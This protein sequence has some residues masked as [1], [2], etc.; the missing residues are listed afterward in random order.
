VFFGDFVFRVFEDVYEPAEDSF[1]F[2]EN[3]AVESGDVVLDMGCGCGILGIVAAVKALRV[4]CV[5]VNP[6]AVRGA[7]EN[8]R[9][10]GVGDRM[11]FV[12]GDLFAPLRVGCVF[13]LVLFNAP[14]L[15]QAE[16]DGD[17]G[18]WVERAWCGGASGRV[19]IDR[20]IADVEKYVKLGGQVLLM[21]SSLCGVEETLRIFEENGFKASVVAECDLP[22][23]EKL[24]LVGAERC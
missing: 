19:V 16:V 23:F 7:W 15:P 20:F 1:L 17:G 14:F 3:L 6:Y 13:D 10:N 5:D 18:S 21:Q 11:F 4:F 2:A 22:F 24:V 12:C 8:A 9:V